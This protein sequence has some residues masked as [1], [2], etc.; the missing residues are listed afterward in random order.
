MGRSE[1]RPAARGP[2]SEGITCCGSSLPVHGEDQLEGGSQSRSPGRPVA[3]ATAPLRP[4][5]HG[6]TAVAVGT[7]SES[8]ATGPGPPAVRTPPPQVAQSPGR[9]GDPGVRGSLRLLQ[10]RSRFSLPMAVCQ[11]RGLLSPGAGIAMIIGV[12]ASIPARPGP[13]GRPEAACRRC[14][15]R[16]RRWPRLQVQVQVTSY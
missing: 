16:R 1:F 10:S 4:V 13:P 12:G 8:G 14:R 5:Q 11:P 6:A 2:V 3:A 9:G 7:D 15:D